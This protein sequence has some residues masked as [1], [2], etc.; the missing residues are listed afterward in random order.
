MSQRNFFPL[1]LAISDILLKEQ[2]ADQHR[3][4]VL[5]SGAT[6]LTIT[7]NVGTIFGRESSLEEQAK[8]S[9]KRCKQKYNVQF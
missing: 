8:E 3:K 5:N 9:L 4:L 7:D 1:K 2:K 6:A